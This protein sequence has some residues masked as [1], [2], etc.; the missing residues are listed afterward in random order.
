MAPAIWIVIAVVFVAGV[1]LLGI[2]SAMLRSLR[3]PVPR[4][5]SVSWPGLVDES[6]RDADVQLRVDMIERLSIVDNEW[7]R[8][9]L[10]RANAEERDARVRSAIEGALER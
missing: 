5:S 6:L 7:S 3:E 9:V 10:Q 2:S 8:G 1:V 4:V